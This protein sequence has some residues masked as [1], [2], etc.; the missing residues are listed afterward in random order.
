LLKMVAYQIESDLVRAVAPNYRRADDEGRT[1]V[2]AALAS[3]A[4]VT[5]AADKRELRVLL[6]PMSSAHRTRAIAALCQ[7]LTATGAVFP[8]TRLRLVYALADR[9]DRTT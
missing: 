6:A 4:D 3:A 1:L 2:Q 8:G 5:V 9:L 7:Q